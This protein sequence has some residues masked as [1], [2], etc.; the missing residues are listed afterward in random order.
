[1]RLVVGPEATSAAFI[2][3]MREARE[4]EA[5]ARCMRSGRR[6][7]VYRD[8]MRPLIVATLLLA[9]LDLPAMAAADAFGSESIDIAPAPPPVGRLE[10]TA[11]LGVTGLAV[12]GT[13][14]GYG[15]DA[16]R[17]P[18]VDASARLLFGDHDVLTFGLT[19]RSFFHQGRG[20]GRQGWGWRVVGGDLMATGRTLFPCM[21]SG[22]LEVHFGV[23]LGLSVAHLDAGTGR[24]PM[25]VDV[26]LREAVAGELDHVAV[27]V[28]FGLDLSVHLRAL[29]LGV[30][31]DNRQ[32]WGMRTQAKRSVA[33]TVGLRVGWA[34]DRRY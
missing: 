18:S 26:E 3:A 11:G 21:S 30:A 8:A 32:L 1:M 20:F 6:R 29:I 9:A 13:P 10:L 28:V 27:G 5:R 19:A 7:A 12:T 33:N 24:G 22:D 17:A 23:N 14:A 4:I 15:Y 31:V 25:N 2:P 16:S 34:L